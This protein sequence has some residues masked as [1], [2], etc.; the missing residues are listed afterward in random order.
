MV[1]S[2][3]TNSK[4]YD[5]RVKSVQK[6]LKEN[7]DIVLLSVDEQADLIFLYKSDYYKKL[8]DN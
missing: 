1:I 7:T 8:G 4:T 2:N 5:S 3:I 6:C